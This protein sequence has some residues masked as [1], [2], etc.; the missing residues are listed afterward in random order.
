MDVLS[1]MDVEQVLSYIKSTTKSDTKENVGSLLLVFPCEITDF[2]IKQL[3]ALLLSRLNFS[4][5]VRLD[6]LFFDKRHCL[7][8]ELEVFLFNLVNLTSIKLEGC[9][10]NNLLNIFSNKISEGRFKYLNNISIIDTYNYAQ[11]FENKIAGN[12]IEKLAIS[13]ESSPIPL[14]HLDLNFPSLNGGEFAFLLSKILVRHD[15]ISLSICGD[16]RKDGIKRLGE[17]V[18]L[19]SQLKEIKIMHINSGKN[20]I[21]GGDDI[22]YTD[23]A[24]QEAPI[25]LKNLPEL[26]SITFSFGY[27][28]KLSTFKT[29]IKQC[30]IS[31]TKLEKLS[32]EGFLS[33]EHLSYLIEIPYLNFSTLSLNNIINTQGQS[34]NHMYHKIALAHKN[35]DVQ[36][37]ERKNKLTLESKAA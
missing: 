28:I 33:E 18:S 2:L 10:P 32:L 26:E 25:F 29:L 19:Q 24:F 34:M 23:E 37:N 27:G 3:F 8:K 6:V 22:S 21:Y 20:G 7:S 1:I 4:G 9:V 15:L 17:L 5:L 16:W 35:L 14:K 30:L 13:L 12:E 11:K 31:S 36:I